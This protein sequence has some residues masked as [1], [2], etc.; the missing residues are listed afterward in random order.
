MFFSHFSAVLTDEIES[1]LKIEAFSMMQQIDWHLFERIQN[2]MIWRNLEIM[3]D[4]RI[5]DIDKRLA[6]FLREISQGYQGMY[7]LLFALDSQ[8]HLIATGEAQNHQNIPDIDYS[9]WQQ[10]NIGQESIYLQTNTGQNNFFALAATISDQFK[11]GSTLGYL[12]TAIDWD[13]IYRILESPLPFEKKSVTSYALLIDQNQRI[14]A[15]S[16]FFRQ[17]KLLDTQLP[18]TWHLP[19]TDKGTQQIDLPFLGTE[20]WLV[21]WA[22][23][24][25]HRSYQGLSWKVIVMTPLDHAFEPVFDMWKILLIFIIFTTLLAAAISLWTAQHIAR[26]IIQLAQFTRDFMLNKKSLPPT[27]KASG[28]IAELSKQF[29]LMVNDLEKSQQDKVRMA[30]FA[31]IAEMAAT[32]AHEIRTPLGILKS[33]AQMLSREKNLSPIAQEMLG[34]IGSETTRLN[35]LVSTLLE[36]SRPRE[37][38]FTKRPLI[39]VIEHAIE[40]LTVQTEKKSIHITLDKTCTQDRLSYDWD[41]MLQVFLNLIN[42]AI[43][44]IAPEG[45]IAIHL[46]TT[47]DH[48]LIHISDD[49]TGV[50]DSQKESIFEPFFTKRQE[51]IGLGLTVVQQMINTHQGTISISDSQWGGACFTIQLPWDQENAQ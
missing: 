3:Q 33:S 40:L 30:K 50:S 45:R 42:N 19:Q 7:P 28:E 11:H 31:V 4:I 6:F 21:S 44:H 17:A 16:D 18:E 15:A 27:I 29:T 23:S 9:P 10:I 5:Q 24:T 14:I 2:I 20:S 1:D 49:G 22:G 37:P 47:P 26:P 46:E 34:F 8:Q 38:Q 39:P 36:S 51:G 13:N 43:Q 48:L 32:M 25:G 12:Y 35:E 41:Q